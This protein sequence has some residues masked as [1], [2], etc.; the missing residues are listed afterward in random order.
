MLEYTVLG[1][2]Q[3]S[4]PVHFPTSGE[5]SLV[6]SRGTFVYERLL[7]Q[8]SAC[9][10]NSKWCFDYN[11]RGSLVRSEVEPSII[12]SRVSNKLGRV[13]F[14]EVSATQVGNVHPLDLI[15]R[16]DANLEFSLCRLA[17]CLPRE[18]YCRVIIMQRRSS[19]LVRGYEWCDETKVMRQAVIGPKRRQARD[20]KAGLSI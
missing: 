6:S 9:R 16:G 20:Q 5:G 1:L 15:R 7:E 12:S 8:Y 18:L 11:A 4:G 14:H 19:F 2:F 10:N 13:S 3:P 17:I